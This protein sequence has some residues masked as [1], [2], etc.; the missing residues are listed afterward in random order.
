MEKPENQIAGTIVE[1]AIEV[2]RTLGAPGLLES[3]YEEALEWELNHRGIQVQRQMT[4]PVVYKGVTLRGPL[5]IDM[6]VQ[7]LVIVENKATTQYNEIF[8]CQTLT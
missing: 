3:V 5:M 8:E 7:N 2:H 1:C 4:L 6:I